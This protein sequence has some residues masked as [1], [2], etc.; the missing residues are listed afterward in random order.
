[1]TDHSNRFNE[2][3]KV[4]DSIDL[5]LLKLFNERARL[6][7]ELS[8]IK[9]SLELDIYD[10]KREKEIIESMLTVNSGPL[11]ER[12]VKD[13]F[14]RIIDESRRVEKMSAHKNHKNL[15]NSEKE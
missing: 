6:A 12:A 8:E 15:P 10:P 7:I 11:D 14:Q 13:L 3:R 2:I 5:K 4:I 1:M 9:K